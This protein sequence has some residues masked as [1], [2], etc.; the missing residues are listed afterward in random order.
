MMSR[1]SKMV[2]ILT[3]ILAAIMIVADLFMG[4]ENALLITSL[5]A[6]VY[7]AVSITVIATLPAFPTTPPLS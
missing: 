3:G 7:I 4:N 6:L 1:T 5:V 2:L